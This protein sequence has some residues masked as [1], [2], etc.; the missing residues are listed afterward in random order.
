MKLK[1]KIQE[2][3]MIAILGFGLEC[4]KDNGCLNCFRKW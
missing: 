2:I 1:V 3:A 4:H